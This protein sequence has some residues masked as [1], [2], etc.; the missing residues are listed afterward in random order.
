MGLRGRRQL[1]S[2]HFLCLPMMSKVGQ[3]ALLQAI[4]AQWMHAVVSGRRRLSN[5]SCGKHESALDFWRG[6]LVHAR[7]RRHYP[8]STVE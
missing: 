1:M 8:Y 4:C 2:R 7:T 3:T 5:V 6:T